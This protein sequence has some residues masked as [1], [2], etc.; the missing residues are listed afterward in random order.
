MLTQHSVSNAN[1]RKHKPTK[2]YAQSPSD[3]LKLQLELSGGT[4]QY[5]RTVYACS[6]TTAKSTTSVDS[7]SSSPVSAA[8]AA[9]KQQCTVS[10]QVDSAQQRAKS[11]HAGTAK[12]LRHS[13]SSSSRNNCNSVI[14]V[15]PVLASVPVLHTDRTESRDAARTRT[16]GKS[17]TPLLLGTGS[18]S[19]R[20][21][22]PDLLS[23]E[24]HNE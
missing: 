4:T 9:L 10:P 14:A 17:S 6:T 22:A 2:A 19:F 8:T 20:V 12:T 5:S 15:S 1:R 21:A 16:K 3:R 18:S 11:M 13:D 7:D 24:V 23:A